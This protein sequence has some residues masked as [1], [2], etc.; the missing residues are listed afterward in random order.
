RQGVVSA[1]SGYY[2]QVDISAGWNR[3]RGSGA[4]AG[5][6]GAANVASYWNGGATMSWEVDLFGKVTAAV[7]QSK[8]QMRLSR[9]EYAAAVVSL[10]AEVATAYVN[11]R[12]YQAEM[13]VAENHAENQLKVVKITEA[14]H[15][16]GLASMLDV[17]QAKTVYYSTIAS[18]PLLETSIRRT[19][20]SLAVLLAENPNDLYAKLDMTGKHQHLDH[21]QIVVRAISLDLI[22]RRPDVVAARENVALAADAVGIAKKDYLPSFTVNGAIGTSAHNASDLF[23]RNSI[24]YTVAPTLS[25]TLFD[26]LARKSATAEAK[27]KLESEIDS[28]NQVVLNAVTEADNALVSYRNDLEY[29]QSLREVVDNSNQTL[30]LSVDLYK[31]GLTAF[32]NVV[33]ALLNVLEYQNSLIVAKGDALVSLINLYKAVGGGWVNDIE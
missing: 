18:I 1:K 11:L 20:N 21:T 16:A 6:H 23:A 3:T 19:I 22:H 33:D 31:K 12:M 10:Q 32:N 4:I 28:Y 2:P 24:T 25:W 26:G 14:R 13:T 8:T 5:H 15:K 9:A 29:M 7:K 30:E 27:L 17:A